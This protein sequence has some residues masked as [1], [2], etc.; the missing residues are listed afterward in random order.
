[1][2]RHGLIRGTFLGVWRLIR[3]QPLCRHGYDPVPQEAMK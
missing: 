1:M 3:C 2:Q